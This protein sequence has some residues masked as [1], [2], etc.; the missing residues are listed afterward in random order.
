MSEEKHIRSNPLLLDA[1]VHLDYLLPRQLEVHTGVERIV[2]DLA[3]GG[4]DTGVA[5]GDTREAGHHKDGD[6]DYAE[7]D[8]ES[9]P[10]AAGFRRTG[11]AQGTSFG[12]HCHMISPLYCY[13]VFISRHTVST[14]LDR[15]EMMSDFPRVRGNCSTPEMGEIRLTSNPKPKGPSF[16]ETGQYISFATI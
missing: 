10:R 7:D 3:E 16:S 14:W 15:P 1:V 5:G 11:F 12:E 9:A 6:D 8:A 13:S 4:D 2:L